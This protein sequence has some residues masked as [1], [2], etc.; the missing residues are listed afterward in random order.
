MLQLLLRCDLTVAF[1][2]GR[3]AAVLLPERFR[4]GCAFGPLPING[5]AS[6]AVG[7][8]LPRSEERSQPRRVDTQDFLPEESKPTQIVM[9]SPLT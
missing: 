7:A 3:L 6:P 8:I 4:G 1:Q 2:S 5:R 9:S